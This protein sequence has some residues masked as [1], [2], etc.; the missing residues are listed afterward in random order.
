MGTEDRHTKLYFM[1][2]MSRAAATRFFEEQEEAVF[3]KTEE[4]ETI[5]TVGAVTKIIF[6]YAQW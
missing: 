4:E 6:E 5:S 2:R 1:T 3:M